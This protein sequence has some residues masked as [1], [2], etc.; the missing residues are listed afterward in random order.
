MLIAFIVPKDKKVKEREI[1]NYLKTNLASYK[2]P[3]RVF[4]KDTFP[5][6]CHIERLPCIIWSRSKNFY[7]VWKRGLR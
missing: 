6:N 7:D 2:I 4:F 5:K 3:L 1:I